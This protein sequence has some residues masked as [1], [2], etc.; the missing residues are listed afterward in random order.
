MPGRVISTIVA[1]LL[2]IISIGCAGSRIDGT[3][4]LVSR[5]HPDGTAQTPPA[6][7]G[8]VTFRD[9]MRNTNVFWRDAQGRGA[10]VAGAAKFELTEYSYRETNVFFMRNSPEEAGVSY[11]LSDISQTSEVVYTERGLRFQLPMHDEPVV[12]FDKDGFTATM[13]GQY[14]DRWRKIEK[15]REDEAKAR[16]AQEKAAR[17]AAEADKK[18]AEEA[19]E[20]EEPQK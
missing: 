3:Y 8:L 16:E 18:A 7:Q 11:D 9:G 4:V 5:T 1:V 17:D 12:E 6:V 13:V 14:V 2:S 20:A 15:V 19:A 10:S